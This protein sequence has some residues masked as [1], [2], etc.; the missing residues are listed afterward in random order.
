M[1]FTTGE[2]YVLG[3]HRIERTLKALVGNNLKARQIRFIEAAL[4]NVRLSL[5]TGALKEILESHF[6]SALLDKEEVTNG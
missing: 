5:A 6:R 3:L 1:I 2:E 4:F